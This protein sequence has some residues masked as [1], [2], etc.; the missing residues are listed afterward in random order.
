M[1]SALAGGPSRF[2][3]LIGIAPQPG[4]TRAIVLDPFHHFRVEL[5]HDGDRITAA[6][7]DT[8]RAPY[9]LCPMAEQRLSDLI[10]T[11][12]TE[13]ILQ[14]MR[15]TDPRQQCTH[16]F[17]IAAL[18]IAAAARGQAASYRMTITTPLARRHVA[19][20]EKDGQK[21][22]RW[23]V[24]G[25]R[26]R[27]DGSSGEVDLERGFTGW[28]AAV[29]SDERLEQ[30]LIL[31]RAWFI[32]QKLGRASGSRVSAP[33]TGGCWVQQPGRATEA[34]RIHNLIE[35]RGDKPGLDAADEAWLRGGEI[36]LAAPHVSPAPA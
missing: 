18:A 24:D 22:L 4:V 1:D 13:E 3:R 28:A 6:R 19:T 27:S 14:V 12:L 29:L 16:Q 32:S 35:L 8:I 17:D 33:E 10:G 21:A 20:L 23:Y 7:S 30:A 34:R 15:V 36:S 9:D 2:V 26:I 25:T 11:P 31:R 5:S